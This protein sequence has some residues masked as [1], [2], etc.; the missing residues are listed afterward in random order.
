MRQ[1]ISFIYGNL[2]FGRDAGDAWAMYRV[3]MTPY[4]GLTAAGKR[5]LLSQIAGFAYTIGADFQLLRVSRDHQGGRYP[6]DGHD[7]RGHLL[8]RFAAAHERR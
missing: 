5:E 8:D 7:A 1:P 4:S 6:T 2:V 3:V